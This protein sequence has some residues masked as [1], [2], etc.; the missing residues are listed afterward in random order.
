MFAFLHG[1]PNH[2]VK[3]EGEK[4]KSLIKRNAGCIDWGALRRVRT[5]KHWG[6]SCIVRIADLQLQH[7][8]RLFLCWRSVLEDKRPPSWLFKRI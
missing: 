3:E 6:S 4:K 1:E 8:I 5:E 7:Y 2:K